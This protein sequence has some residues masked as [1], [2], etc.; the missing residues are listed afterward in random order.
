[1]Y[2]RIIRLFVL[3]IPYVKVDFVNYHAIIMSS[4]MIM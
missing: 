3:K 2:A 1:M 4:S